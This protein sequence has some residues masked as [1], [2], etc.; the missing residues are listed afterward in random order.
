MW[1]CRG[2]RYDAQLYT[3]DKTH[4]TE[5]LSRDV[6]HRSAIEPSR[7]SAPSAQ[8]IE[9]PSARGQLLEHV[10]QVGHSSPG[11]LQRS[12]GLFPSWHNR[13]T[14][15]RRKPG[16]GEYRAFGRRSPR[17]RKCGVEHQGR[18]GPLP[19]ESAENGRTLS[20]TLLFPAA[21]KGSGITLRPPICH[22][23][24][25]VLATQCDPS[26]RREPG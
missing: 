13:A 7:E 14:S 19:G 2:G 5:Q 6:S 8:K 24:Q 12:R 20:R 16:S 9:P 17:D 3:N 15:A 21:A 4:F 22:N 10:Q 26:R 23:I 11:S 18:R 25:D 1:P